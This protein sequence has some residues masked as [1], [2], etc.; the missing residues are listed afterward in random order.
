ML[1]CFTSE[2]WALVEHVTADAGLHHHDV[3]GVTEGIMKL[4]RQACALLEHKPF[5]RSLVLT[6]VE[7]DCCTLGDGQLPPA[8]DAVAEQ[9]CD[10]DRHPDADERDRIEPSPVGDG[11]AGRSGGRCEHGPETIP[12]RR[13]CE[14]RIQRKEHGVLDDSHLIAEGRVGDNEDAAGQKCDS[15]RCPPPPHGGRC[16]HDQYDRPRISV[17]IAS[18]GRRYQHDEN[19][20]KRDDSHERGVEHPRTTGDRRFVRAEVGAGDVHASMMHPPSPAVVPLARDEASLFRGTR[21]GEHLP[22][23]AIRGGAYHWP[24]S[25]YPHGDH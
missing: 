8:T 13:P 19:A 21:S 7:L 23:W 15:G 1:Q 11:I 9:R 25:E 24:M 16:G 14:H 12:P 17:A 2:L 5:H 4:S 22:L 6:V 20:N 3:D 18:R 10:Q